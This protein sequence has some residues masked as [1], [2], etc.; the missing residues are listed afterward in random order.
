MLRYLGPKLKKLK[1]FN[2]HM[3]PGFS[4]KYSILNKNFIKNNKA[5]IS[6]YLLELL[7]KQKLKFTFSLTE[8][9]IKKYILFIHKYNYKKFNISTIIEARLDKILFNIGYSITIA[10]ARQLIVHGYFFV[11]FK[12]ITNPSFLIKIGDII[13]LSSKSSFIFK[14]CK[15]NLY[16]KYIKTIK[17][18]L[19]VYI[20]KKTCL[21]IF[22]SQINNYT[23]NSYNNLLIIQYYLH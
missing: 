12:L 21:S 6:F 13:S 19:N 4:T 16:I 5:I 9:L 2:I 10:Q 18:N 23:F 11:N 22:Y 17:C 14:L 1:Q 3:H 7:E 15:K 8:K 20:C